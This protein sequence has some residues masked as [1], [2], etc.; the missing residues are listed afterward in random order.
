MIGDFNGWNPARA[1][2][3]SPSSAGIWEGFVPDIGPGARLQVSHRSH[4]IS[5]YTVDKADPY[6][7]AAE[8]R[9][10]TASRV[11]DLESYSWQDAEWMA[12]RAKRNSADCAHFDLRSAS[13]FLEAGAG[14]RQ[15]LADLSR[16]GAAARRLRP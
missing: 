5:K 6:G 3:C 9:P 1:I 12:N 15:S 8:I 11:W 2:L 13:R 7:F 4:A 10:Q 14:G 16:T